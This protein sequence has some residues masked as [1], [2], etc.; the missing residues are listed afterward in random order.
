[1]FRSFAYFVLIFSVLLK[2]GKLPFFTFH[3]NN[4]TTTDKIEMGKQGIPSDL[5]NHFLL[6]GIYHYGKKLSSKFRMRCTCACEKKG[7]SSGGGCKRRC[8]ALKTAIIFAVRLLW[9]KQTKR[10]RILKHY[11]EYNQSMVKEDSSIV[12]T[13]HYFRYTFQWAA[14]ERKVEKV[15]GLYRRKQPVADTFAL[16]RSWKLIKNLYLSY[17]I[18]R[19]LILIQ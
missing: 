1:M 12:K 11:W 18:N 8:N 16:A 7:H 2:K 19:C 3:L 10:H 14:H 15:Y 13:G 17:E 9:D 4:V 6:N 5:A